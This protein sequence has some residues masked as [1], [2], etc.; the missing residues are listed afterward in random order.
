MCVESWRTVRIVPP[1]DKWIALVK[2]KMAELKL[3]QEKLAERIDKSQG[4]V[5][6]W[7]NKRR[8]PELKIMNAI[9]E[10]LELG[11]LEVVLSVRER[12]PGAREIDAANDDDLAVAFRQKLSFRY[13]IS[14]WA[15]AGEVCEPGQ[16]AYPPG[17]FEATDYRAQGAAFW[18]QVMGDAMTAPVGISVPEGMLV[19]VDPDLPVEPAAMVVARWPGSCEA[20]FRQL[21]EEGGQRYLKPLNPTYPKVLYSDE[22]RIIG[23]VVQATIKFI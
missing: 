22:C 10:A 2:A 19:L 17:R 12:G 7:L 3:T 23:V 21:I 13:P 5:G 16:V 18:L 15:Q 8:T 14:D 1:M 20:M 11:H 6:H 4:A 9:L